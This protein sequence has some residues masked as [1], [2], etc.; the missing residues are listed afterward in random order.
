MVV[1][2]RTLSPTF[3]DDPAYTSPWCDWEPACLADA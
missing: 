3:L 1:T 2:S